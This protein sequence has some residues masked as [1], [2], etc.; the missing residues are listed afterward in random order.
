MVVI[1]DLPWLFGIDQSQVETLPQSVQAIIYE[2]P[3]PILLKCTGVPHIYLLE[4]GQKRWIDTIATFEDRGY[5]W[6]DVSLIQCDDLN[7]IPDGAPI[8]EDAGAPPQP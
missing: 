7:A 4:D 3:D 2:Q 5:V 6:R 1:F 8:P